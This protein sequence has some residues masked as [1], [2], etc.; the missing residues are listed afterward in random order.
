MDGWNGKSHPSDIQVYENMTD[1]LVYEGPFN[2]VQARL[3]D[4]G[5]T[6]ARWR[7]MDMRDSVRSE[8]RKFEKKTKRG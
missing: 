1:L 8:L 7:Q 4:P 3:R 2:K 5:M 6:A